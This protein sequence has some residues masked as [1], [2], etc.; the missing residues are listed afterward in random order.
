M[1]VTCNSLVVE[2]FNDIQLTCN[3]LDMI[4]NGIQLTCNA[5]DMD[6]RLRVRVCLLASLRVVSSTCATESDAPVATADT[7]AAIS[8][9]QWRV[10]A[11]V[12]AWSVVAAA[13]AVSAHEHAHNGGRYQSTG[14]GPRCPVKT[15]ART[16]IP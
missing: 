8:N 2:N 13:A 10:C 12:W 16:Q 7:L 14:H 5:L 4:E 9:D 15:K 3:A 11:C 6:V 1:Q